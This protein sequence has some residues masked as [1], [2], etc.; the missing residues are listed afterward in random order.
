LGSSLDFNVYQTALHELS[1]NE[2]T[3][4]SFGW[5]D[6]YGSTEYT[7]PPGFT[8]WKGILLSEIDPGFADFLQD[9]FATSIRVEE[10]LWGGVEIDGIPALNNAEMTSG[11]E[12][13]Y[14]EPEEPVFGLSLKR[15]SPCVPAAYPRLA[16][17]GKRRGRR[18]SDLAG[19][20]HTLRCGDRV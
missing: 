15:R 18:K 2:L 8:T 19:L 5:I 7:P 4:T 12:A 10:I 6:W 14:L 16:R 11:S 3:G 1:E 17:D 9:D 13:D 20:L